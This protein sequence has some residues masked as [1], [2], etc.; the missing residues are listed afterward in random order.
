MKKLIMSIML[1]A[2][3]LSAF[4][5]QEAKWLRYPAIS[6]DGRTI[7]F[8]YMGNL[9]TVSSEGG[10]ATPVTI[11]NDYCTRPVWSH[12]G[13]TIA[14]SSDRSGNFD[15]YTMPVKGGIPVRLTYYSYADYPLDFTADDT[16]VLFSSYRNNSVNVVRFPSNTFK[17]LY[18][19]PA[20]GGREIVVSEAGANE[21]KYS[22][23]GSKLV[24]EDVKGYE[25]DY[26]KHHTSGVTRDIW[27][28][29]IAADKYTKVS[30]FNGEDRTPVFS[31][32]GVNIFYVNEKDGTLNLYKRNTETGAEAQLTHFKGFPVRELS[33]SKDNVLT[34]VWKGDIYTLKE[35]EEARKLDIKVAGNTGY[36][37]V[38]TLNINSLSEFETSPDGKEL[39]IVNRGEVFV[40]SIRDG[41]TK[42]ITNTPY[43]ERM[44]T[45]SKD[46]KYLYYS[47]EKNGIWGI[48]RASLSYPDEKYFYASTMIFTEPVVVD[49]TNNFKPVCSPDN[50]KIAYVHERNELCVFNL[51]TKQTY[52]L[53]PKGMNFSYSDGD[54][55]FSWSPDSNWLMS[56]CQNGYSFSSHTAII[57]ADGT[58]EIKYPIMSGFGDG[59]SQWGMDGKMMIYETALHG[60]KGAIT[61]SGS[62]TDIYAAFFD[63]E[64]FDKFKLNKDDFDL[65]KEKEDAE[66]SKKDSIDKANTEKDKAS[67]RGKKDKKEEVKPAEVY[68]IDFD[69]IENRK[70]R[71]TINSGNLSGFALSKDGSKLY[72]VRREPSGSSLWSTDTRTKETKSLAKLSG[73]SA[74]ELSD[75]GSTITL[76]NGG[77]PMTVNTASGEM[78]PVKINGKMELDRVAERA[79]ILDHVYGQ[80]IKK[81]YDPTIHGIDWKMY[82]DEYAKFLPYINNNQDFKVLLSEMLGEL[83]ASHTGARYYASASKEQTSSLGMIFDQTYTGDGILISEIVK[84]GIADKT[85]N[86]IKAGDIITAINGKEIKAEDNW[87]KYLNNI[88]G[89]NVLLTV[90]AV[91]GKSYTQQMRP[92]IDNGSLMYKRWTKMMEKMVDSLSNGRLGYVHVQSMNEGSYREVVENVMGKNAAKEALIVDT[93]FNGGG[94]LHDD[95]CTFLSGQSYMNWAPQSH[96]AKD[97]ESLSRWCK[98]SIVIM[99]E[100]NYSDAFLFPFAYKE[101]GIGKLVGMPVAGTG[102]AVWWERV[103]DPTIVFGIPMVASTGRNK[104]ITENVDLLPD[105]KV[106]LPFNECLNGKDAQLEAA[107]KEMLKAIDNK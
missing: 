21:A 66:K 70:V 41:R 94:F 59:S 17:E 23:D 58:G 9:Y 84:G 1:C 72:Y 33:V 52:T 100:G 31:S 80:V 67:K 99:S 68:N 101:L 3:A 7:I 93:R 48:Y 56:D 75:D 77:S 35:G 82:H 55:S 63:A 16:K 53:I 11:G 38:E 62:E 28:Y 45:W 8:G 43:Q 29:N 20:V 10:V 30:D 92:E 64:T 81:F 2:I 24:F 97:S 65:L 57:K 4:A 49:S 32:D 14:Y 22:P 5:Q 105:I 46:G 69:G 19:V 102:T 54:W 86:R 47:A 98:P 87:Y 50:K 15:I 44:I 51:E 36:A 103:I 107:V 89:E 79:Y 39:A 6:P 34:F 13:K 42:R 90:K 76:I 95:L 91:D 27:I 85:D 71:L 104:V 73:G 40:V 25:D 106:E 37:S 96:F 18:T 78:K 26:R 83:N 60:M 61:Q 74:I 88:A 12:D